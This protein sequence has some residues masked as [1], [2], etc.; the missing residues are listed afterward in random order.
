MKGFSIIFLKSNI[1]PY[2]PFF[3]NYLFNLK[4]MP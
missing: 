3:F 2:F 1:L 4:G